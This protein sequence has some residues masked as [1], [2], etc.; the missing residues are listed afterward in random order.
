MAKPDRTGQTFGKLTIIADHGG[1][2]LQ[3]RCDCGRKGSYPRAITKPSYRGPKACPW[4]LGS[5]CEECG[6][7]IP[8]K[9][10][11]PAKTCSEA[12]R[13]ARAARRERERYDQIKDTDEFKTKRADY[14]RRLD[15]AMAA[16][17]ELA[18][19]V[20]ETRRRAVRAWRE[21][22]LAD[23][24]LRG[25]Y[26]MRAQQNEQRRLERIRS[27]PDAYAEHLRKQRTWYRTLSDDDYQRIFVE[28]RKERQKRNPQRNSP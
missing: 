23:P 11:M 19:S 17:P 25:K 1:A 7:I 6:A 28:G 8:H 12:C 5:P 3:C 20:R 14:L 24:D 4:C 9:G 18:E 2:Q 16:D 13:S 27:D 21:R 15:A 26:R 22:Q 10:R